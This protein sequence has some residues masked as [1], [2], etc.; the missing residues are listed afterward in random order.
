MR[1]RNAVETAWSSHNPTP[2]PITMNG[3]STSCSHQATCS[4]LP[5]PWLAEPM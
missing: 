5:M 4:T 3:M 2:T 1:A